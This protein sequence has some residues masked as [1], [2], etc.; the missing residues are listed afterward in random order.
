MTGGD[1]VGYQKISKISEEGKSIVS[2]LKMRM[3]IF[4]EEG[5]KSR[6]TTEIYTNAIWRKQYAVKH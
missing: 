5:R 6:Q 1:D 3:E 2:I 4:V